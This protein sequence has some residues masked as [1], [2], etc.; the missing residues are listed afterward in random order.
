MYMTSR[1]IVFLCFLAASCCLSSACKRKEVVENQ[2]TRLQRTW[3]LVKTAT[4][5]DGN[6]KL[7]DYEFHAIS[8]N[9]D[10]QITFHA[11]KT[12]NQTVIANNVTTVYPFTWVL[13][14]NDTITRSGTGHDVRK[15]HIEDISNASMTLISPPPTF[16][17]FYYQAK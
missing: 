7:D 2:F 5:S 9:M 13:D 12:G 3:K 14:E 16:V 15:Y 10:D 1:Q 8:E 17:A 6:G 4:D 11:D